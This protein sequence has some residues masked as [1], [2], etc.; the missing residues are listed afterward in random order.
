MKTLNNH[1]I[2]FDAE[3]PMCRLYTGAFVNTGILPT[4]GRTAYQQLP[5]A[6]CPMVDR[7]R[8]VNEIALVDQ[9]TGEVTYGIKS[10]FKIFGHAVPLLRPLFTFGPFVWVMSK[11]YSFIS[12]NRRVII[13]AN[14]EDVNSLQP[15]FKLNYRLL[16]LLFTWAVTSFILTAYVRLMPNMLP[17]GSAFREYLVCAGQIL[18]QGCVVA[19][20]ARDKAWAYLGNMMTISFGGALLLA[21]VLFLAPHLHL[22]RLFY[23]L[24][25]FLVVGLM[26]LEHIR[27]TRILTLI[28]ALSASWVGYRLLVL[29]FI[30][31]AD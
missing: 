23:L 4:N 15:T 31:L 9:T 2:L 16:Y 19:A 12:Y 1:L 21:P 6:A 7:Q 28:P 5:A 20:I 8:D 30:F 25:F 27:R 29:L 3:C 17:M 18:F 22:P 26:F 10:L 14:H 24:Y 13:P 11:L